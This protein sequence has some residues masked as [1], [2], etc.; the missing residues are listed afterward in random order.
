MTSVLPGF[1]TI[2]AFSRGFVT[3]KGVSK[4]NH[5]IFTFKFPLQMGLN[6][7][8]TH[9][10]MNHPCDDLPLPWNTWSIYKC[11]LTIY[12][13]SIFCPHENKLRR[14]SREELKAWQDMTEAIFVVHPRWAYALWKCWQS[15]YYGSDRPGRIFPFSSSLPAQAR[16]MSSGHISCSWS[17]CVKLCTDY[18]CTRWASTNENPQCK[19]WLAG[20]GLKITAF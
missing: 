4:N 2:N 8:L 5:N 18:G 15:N 13:Q 12:P 6:Y 19:L 17:T 20:K 9:I 7:I 11:N 1:A 16:T 10:F 3:P 14:M